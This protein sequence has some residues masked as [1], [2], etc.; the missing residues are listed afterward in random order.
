MKEAYLWITFLLTSVVVFGQ[1][2][3][4]R[5]CKI[6]LTNSLSQDENYR[7]VAR[8]LLDNEFTIEY[9][10][11]ALGFINTEFFLARYANDPKLRIV[12]R[13]GEV[14]VTGIIRTSGPDTPVSYYH[15][16]NVGWGRNSRRSFKIMHDI[17]MK[18]PHEKVEYE[19]IQSEK[20]NND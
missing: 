19:F 8:I 11:K 14:I 2:P 12:L 13:D 20:E 1:D 4:E 9:A 18:F 6:I 5:A 10:D 15:L 3:P 7:Q 16:Q 17:A